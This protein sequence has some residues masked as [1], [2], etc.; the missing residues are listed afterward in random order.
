MNIKDIVDKIRHQTQWINDV[1]V[2]NPNVVEMHQPFFSDQYEI[3]EALIDAGV[4]IDVIVSTGVLLEDNSSILAKT[5]LFE[6]DILHELK[7]SKSILFY[8][9]GVLPSGK[10]KLRYAR[11]PKIIRPLPRYRKEL[12]KC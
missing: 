11:S 5:S 8:F 9:W 10:Q 3:I 7:K 12:N 6:D 1:N 2:G 4:Y